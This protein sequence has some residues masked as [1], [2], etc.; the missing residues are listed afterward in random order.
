[1]YTYYPVLTISTDSQSSFI[2]RSPA[3]ASTIG[4]FQVNLR[5][6]ISSVRTSKVLSILMWLDVSYT[7]QTSLS[8][9]FNWRNWHFL[10]FYS[11][12]SQVDFDDY[13]CW[14]SFTM[15]SL[16]V[17]F[18]INWSLSEQISFQSQVELYTSIKRHLVRIVFLSY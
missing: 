8:P 2:Y 6:I 7:L 10:F 14:V 4:S 3:G 15:F 5:H 13:F 16:S 12:V 18:P 1:M 9:S 17:I 11:V